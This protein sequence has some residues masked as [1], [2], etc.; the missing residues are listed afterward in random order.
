M[1]ESDW[2]GRK[3]GE[4]QAADRQNSWTLV[5]FGGERS[6]GTFGR[7]GSDGEMQYGDTFGCL[8]CEKTKNGSSSDQILFARAFCF[9]KNMRKSKQMRIMEPRDTRRSYG[10]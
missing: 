6:R 9:C 2:P 8:S 4:E 7:K 5:P 3:D 1:R 10:S